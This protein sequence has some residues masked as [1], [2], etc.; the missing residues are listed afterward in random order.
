M[1]MGTLEDCCQHSLENHWP[2]IKK[3]L[4]LRR[5]QEDA[6][7]GDARSMGLGFR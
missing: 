3:K 6:G 5:I 1:E 2:I 7:L 4:S